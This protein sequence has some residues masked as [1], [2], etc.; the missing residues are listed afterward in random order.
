[1]SIQWAL[2][3]LRDLLPNDLHKRLP[4]AS[5]DPFYE[6]QDPGIL[7]T[8]NG[9]TGELMKTVPLVKMY[10]MSRRKFRALCAEG[11]DVKVILV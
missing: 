6:P 7:P 9:A 5:V 8:L 3:L 2:P 11:I 1:M 10:R 4:T